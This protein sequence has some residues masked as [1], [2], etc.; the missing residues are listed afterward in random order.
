MRGAVMNRVL[1]LFFST[2]FLLMVGCA[3]PAPS[4]YTTSGVQSM[5]AINASEGAVV[6]FYPSDGSVQSPCYINVNGKHAG[7][8]K[9]G[10][11][12]MIP[13]S[14]GN[15]IISLENDAKSQP[16][17][18]VEITPG[19]REYLKAGQ[20]SDFLMAKATL[21]ASTREEAKYHLPLLK[22]I[23]WKH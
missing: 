12:A 11:Y 7:V 21:E 10:T 18:M 9:Q 15:Y 1:V 13:L 6:V 14:A 20:F 17:V 4:S 2:A 19:V 8:V 23:Q 22:S 5:P 3:T 16:Q